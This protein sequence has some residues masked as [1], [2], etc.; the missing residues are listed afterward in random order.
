MGYIILYLQVVP[1]GLRELLLVIK[2]TYNNPPVFI[3]ES[4]YC[5]KNVIEDQGR[6]DYYRVRLKYFN[7]F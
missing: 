4:G 5:D 7:Y 6:V 1:W 2:N 3:T